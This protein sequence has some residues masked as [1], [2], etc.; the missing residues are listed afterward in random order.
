M[1]MA[2]YRCAKCGKEVE[3]DL[4]N[5]REVRCPYCSSKILYKPRPKVARRVKA[6]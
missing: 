5:T 4:E 6:I 2:V 1:V 3:L